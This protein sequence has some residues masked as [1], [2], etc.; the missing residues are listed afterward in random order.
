MESTQLSRRKFVVTAVA[1]AAGAA[2][3]PFVSGR[4]LAQDTVNFGV[5]T[6]HT[7]SYAY[8]GDLIIK[9]ATLAL[10]ERNYEVLGKKLRLVV[11]DDEAKAAVGVR[12]LS[13]IISTENVRF[14][15][16]NYSSAVGLAEAELAQKHKVLQYAAGGSED[17]TG[18]RCGRYTFQWSAS[19]YTALKAVIDYVAKEMPRA[20]RWYT[21]TADYVFGHSLL[22]YARAVGAQKGIEIIGNDN[23]PLGERQYTQY[24]TKAIAAKPD[25][26][27]LLNAGSDAVTTVRQFHG[28]GASGIAVVGPWTMEVEQLRELAPE[29]RQGLVLGQNYYHT[30]DNPANASFVARYQKKYNSVPAYA[31]AYGYDSFRTILVAMERAKS[32]NVPDVLRAMEGLKFEGVLG[33]ATIDPNTH[34]T[35]RPYFVVKVKPAAQMKGADDFADIVHVG[36]DPQPKNMNECKGLGPI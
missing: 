18:S 5:V 21:F 20:R 9:G 29:M 3:G 10:E 30:I 16:G 14:F 4:A 12:R 33:A 25:V 23:H 26:L 11:R 13:E 22:K 7:G 19:P 28:Y 2:A 24:L 8:A 31:G 6:P 27:C 36:S 35:V 1:S 34:Q 15:N 17:F 32:T